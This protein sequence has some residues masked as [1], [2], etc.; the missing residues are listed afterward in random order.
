MPNVKK[1]SFRLFT[2]LFEM[3]ICFDFA[4]LFI[5]EIFRLSLVLFL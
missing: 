5:A 4:R 3:L 1:R 2:N